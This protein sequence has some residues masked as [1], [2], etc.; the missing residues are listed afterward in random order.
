VNIIFL[1]DIA[2]LVTIYAIVEDPVPERVD[3]DGLEAG[4]F[5]KLP[6][7]WPFACEAVRCQCLRQIAWLKTTLEDEPREMGAVAVRDRR[8]IVDQAQLFEHI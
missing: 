1:V 8:P 5:G 6:H 7:R 3:V 4:S 2:Q